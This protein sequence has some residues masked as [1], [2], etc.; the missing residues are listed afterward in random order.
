MIREVVEFVEVVHLDRP[1]DDCMDIAV[2]RSVGCG[3]M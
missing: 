2:V 3:G 1:C